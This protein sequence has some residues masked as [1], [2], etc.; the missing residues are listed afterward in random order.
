MNQQDTIPLF[1]VG[2]KQFKVQA[3]N[4]DDNY[5]S[6]KLEVEKVVDDGTDTVRKD[7]VWSDAEVVVLDS[8][9]S[10]LG[11]SAE[12]DFFTNVIEPV[13]DELKVPARVIRTEN[14]KSVTEFASTFKPSAPT[15]IIIFLSGDTTIS[16]FINALKPNEARK[17][18]KERAHLWFLPLPFGTANAWATSLGI[19]NPVSAFGEFLQDKL[20]PK[21]FPLYKAKFPNGREV[22]FF[23]ILSIGFHANLLHLCNE[24][25]FDNIGVEKFR[26]AAQEILQTYDLDYSLQLPAKLPT[27]HFAYFTLI[28][29]PFLEKTYMPSPSS[30]PLKS[31]LHLLGYITAF[32]KTKLIEKIMRGYYNKPQEDISADGV[33]YQPFSDDFVVSFEDASDEDPNTKFEICCDGHLLNM[34]D[35]QVEGNNFDGKLQIEFLKDYSAFDLKVLTPK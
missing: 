21:S 10:G 30:D 2:E 6:F 8:V 26:I 11:R 23:I 12:N 27:Q 18:N 17:D 24:E 3:K 33:V 16:E 34:R 1:K 29:T 13:F 9:K 31:E 15:T 5:L 25:R 35:L 7:I 19:Q 28:N 22:V 4:N 20:S 32:D 14:S